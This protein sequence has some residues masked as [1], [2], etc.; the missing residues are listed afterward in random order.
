MSRLPRAGAQRMYSLFS[1]LGSLL[2]PLLLLLLPPDAMHLWWCCC[3]SSLV[4]AQVLDPFAERWTALVPMKRRRTGVA[5]AAGPH[6][7]LYAVG[8]SLLVVCCF[9]VVA[10]LHFLLLLLLLLFY[11][12]QPREECLLS[13]ASCL[14]RCR[15][16]VGIIPQF[17]VNLHGCTSIEVFFF[18][19]FKGLIQVILRVE[20][21][22]A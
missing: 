8:A 22:H 7:R 17:T 19:V 15:L 18:F 10:L 12:G 5:V 3:S 2:S 16:L 21:I 20:D 4:F 13:L 1:L 14:C 6:G 9:C 11:G